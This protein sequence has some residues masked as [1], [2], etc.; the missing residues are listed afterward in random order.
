[1]KPKIEIEA[2]L[3]KISFG[4][5]PMCVKDDNVFCNRDCDAK[6]LDCGKGFCLA[7]IVEHGKKVHL[8]I[9]NND[10]CSKEKK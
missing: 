9:D 1:M 4:H 6:C 3:E 7:H 10:H 2:I 8:M 5:C